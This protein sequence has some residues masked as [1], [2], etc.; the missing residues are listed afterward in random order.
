MRKGERRGR[1]STASELINK[2]AALY[3][4]KTYLEIG[5]ADGA[6]FHSVNIE[7]KT[8]VD[9]KFAF[10][11]EK[12]S[13]QPGRF[14][15]NLK[16]DDFFREV[17]REISESSRDGDF[18]WDIIYIDG[19]HTYEQAMRDFVN[20][21]RYTR[22]RTILI[23]D[24]TVPSNPWAAI[25]NLAICAYFRD[26]A[27]VVDGS[28][29]GDVFKCV[30]ELR[31]F[32]PDFSYATVI[33]AGNPR[34]VVWKMA[35]KCDRPRMFG[36][37]AE[38]ANLDYFTMLERCAALCPMPEE[39]LFSVIGTEVNTPLRESGA[40]IPSLVKPLHTMGEIKYLKILAGEGN[41]RMGEK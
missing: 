21:L 33:G 12:Y 18:T 36:D 39:K 13:N 32:W 8:A 29:Q 27:G 14:Y 1:M 16:S 24:D 10:D 4:A 11:V 40:L 7:H 25:P 41:K 22:E 37:K 34:T 15:Y 5:V 19:L 26:L 23:F 17:E 31:D 20:S 6:T 28:W 30:F 2:L 38:I 35:K 3:N 9:P